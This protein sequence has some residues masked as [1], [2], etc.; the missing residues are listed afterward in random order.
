LKTTEQITIKDLARQLNVS[1]ATI[2]RAL[3]DSPDI[4]P[5]TKKMVLELAKK[6]DYHPNSIAQSLVTRRSRIIGVIIPD[7]VI[8]F[9]SS[10][11][12]GIQAAAAEAGYN[13]IICQ[14]NESYQTEVANTQTL[15]SNRVDGLLVSVSRETQD[16]AHFETVMNKGIP[17]VFFNRVNDKLPVSRVEVDDY[18]GAYQAT[19]HLISVGC[20]RIAH[21]AG[22]LNVPLFRKRLE[23]YMDALQAHNLPVDEQYI[24]A[25]GIRIEDGVAATR[26]LLDISPLPDAIFAVCDSAAFGAM[27][28]IKE[29]GL[30]IPDDI[31]LAGFT[32]E[33]VT[34]L[35]EPSLTTVSQPTF[36]IGWASAQMLLDQLSK[37]PHTFVPQ[38][39]VLKTQLIIRNSTARKQ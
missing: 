2:S 12:S 16:F 3:R 9:Y 15:V 39:K 22:P 7:I 5:E 30:R 34:A 13:V 38:D 19:A 6:L 17:L 25:C 23:G 18:E 33:P 32:N 8:H 1:I 27:M 24:I 14:S 4:S 10:A 20:T 21:L 35:V 37:E 26:K 11:I 29:R 28:I 31:A 36:D